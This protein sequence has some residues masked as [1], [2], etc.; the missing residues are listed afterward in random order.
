M[1]GRGGMA[2]AYLAS[3]ETSPRA[4]LVVKRIRYDK[5]CSDEYH[6][7]FVLEA[8]VAS[9]LTHRNL[10]R[11][12]EFGCIE[13]HPYIVMDQVRGYGLERILRVC[14]ERRRRLPTLVAIAIGLGVLDGLSAMHRVQDDIGRPRPFLHRD[15]T[16]SN[17]IINLDGEP[18]II[19]FGIA[20]DINGPAITLPGQVIGTSRYMS[21]EHR[22]AEYT[23]ARADVF[24]ASVVL[25]E[26]L[27]GQHPWPPLEG[28]KELL[29]TTFDPPEISSELCRNIG[30]D[31]MNVVFR[32]LSCQPERRFVD[33]QAMRQA[34]LKLCP[35]AATSEAKEEVRAY[36]SKLS[37]PM[38]EELANPIETASEATLPSMLTQW[39]TESSAGPN[40]TPSKP[41]GPLNLPPLPPARTL[42]VSFEELES[43]ALGRS[44][45]PASLALFAGLALAIFGLAYVGL[46]YGGL[47][48]T[49]LL[50]KP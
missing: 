12:Q 28:I 6:K 41:T 49:L 44:P 5:V 16:P 37:I 47:N 33:A 23:D 19:D 18:V 32:G 13:D 8:Q 45:T 1:L 26:L 43:L 10:V 30:T 39:T 22:R 15:V 3:R 48:P 7:R 42:G 31:I 24:S 9:R 36:V 14:F 50:G 4:K 21:P 20:K 25:F 29:R 46:V 35:A 2:E 11:F 38:D 27:T 40:P 17:I 34:L